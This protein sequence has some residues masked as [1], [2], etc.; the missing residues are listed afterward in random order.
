MMSSVPWMRLGVV[1]CLVGHVPVGTRIRIQ[2]VKSSPLGLQF[3][4]SLLHQH[5]L[6]AAAIQPTSNDGAPSYRN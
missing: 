1:I 2:E 6:E 3:T 4:A 5:R